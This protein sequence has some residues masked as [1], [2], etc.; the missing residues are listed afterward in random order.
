MTPFEPTHLLT[1]SSQ[2]IILS[3]SNSSTCLSPWKSHHL[4]CIWIL[5]PLVQVLNC[6]WSYHSVNEFIEWKILGRNTPV[7]L[8]LIWLGC[9]YTLVG[10]SFM[11]FADGYIHHQLLPITTY[12]WQ[13][14]QKVHVTVNVSGSSSKRMFLWYIAITY[15][16][17]V[18]LVSQA[19]AKFRRFHQNEQGMT[20]C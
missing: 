16:A 17:V 19:V 13:K 10:Q 3:S 1:T 15:H 4:S 18:V 14:W 9:S 20:S 6:S 11:S 2:I 7:K 8:I 12:C 5:F